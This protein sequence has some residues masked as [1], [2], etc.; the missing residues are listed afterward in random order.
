MA[1]SLEGSNESDFLTRKLGIY[2]SLYC[3]LHLSITFFLILII[4]ILSRLATLQKFEDVTS[5]IQ[6]KLPALW[7]TFEETPE[8][9]TTASLPWKILQFITSDLKFINDYVL[10]LLRQTI[11]SNASPE[12]KLK[13]L[14][15]LTAT[16]DQISC[17]LTPLEMVL[18]ANIKWKPGRSASVL[19]SC[20]ALCIH[21][22]VLNNK[23]EITPSNVD[24]Y[25]EAF[26]HLVE[27]EV[28][29]SRL[30]AI[31][32]LRRCLLIAQPANI[33]SILTSKFP[34]FNPVFRPIIVSVFP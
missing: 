25:A 2:T 27:D 33:D 24:V 1:L 18:L 20:A 26:L 34:F 4:G 19:R 11:S 7:E 22:A 12:I 16:M 13:S 31:R 29:N 14:N 28:L 3:L 9:W 17:Q 30:A 5:M 6:Q 21:S 8:M 15:M 32:V 23:L 10:E